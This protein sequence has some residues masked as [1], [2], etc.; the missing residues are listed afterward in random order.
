MY[1]ANEYTLRQRLTLYITVLVVAAGTGWG[2]FVINEIMTIRYQALGFVVGTDGT[3]LD[4]VEVILSLS[5]PPASG[6]QLDAF[7]EQEG[8]SHGRHSPGGHLQRTVG[9]VIGLSGSSGA[10][11]VRVTGRTGASHAIRLGLDTDGRPAFEVAWLVFRKQGYPD[12]T[13]TVSILGWRTSPS[14]WGSFANKLPRI[15]MGRD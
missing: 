10:Y 9:P 2:L 14:D 7:F 15:T 4:G 3:P 13:K 6:P 8:I 12:L 11:I 5:P 1:M